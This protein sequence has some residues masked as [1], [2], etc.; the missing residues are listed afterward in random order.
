ML[1][2]KPPVPTCLKVANICRIL[3]FLAK[4]VLYWWIYIATLGGVSGTLMTVQA[5]AAVPAF[6]WYEFWR[7]GYLVKRVDMYILQW[8]LAVFD[9][10]AFSI[11]KCM[12]FTYIF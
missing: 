4:L 7:L 9:A 10:T 2:E 11:V 8:S 1:F 12:F 5:I 6:L 3:Q